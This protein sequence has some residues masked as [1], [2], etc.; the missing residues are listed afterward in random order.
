M[1]I[2]AS[3]LNYTNA[4]T[5]QHLCGEMARNCVELIAKLTCPLTRCMLNADKHALWW[6]S[7]VTCDRKLGWEKKRKSEEQLRCA[8]TGLAELGRFLGQVVCK[9]H[10]TCCYFCLIDSL[11][12]AALEPQ[13][14][15]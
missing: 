9:L 1:E 15:L 11:N 7:L 2:K 14:T 10:S 6:S 8:S 13:E 4:L 5:A 3:S 12:N